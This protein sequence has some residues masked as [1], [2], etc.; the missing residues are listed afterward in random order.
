MYRIG[1]F[2][3]LTKTTIKTL[4][5][6]DEVGLVKPHRVDDENGYRYYTTAQLIQIHQIL[7]LRQAGLS[8]SEIQDIMSGNDR[9]EILR[10]K[11]AELEQELVQVQRRIARVNHILQHMKEDYFMEY[12]AIIK[13]LPACIV[14]SKRFILPNYDALFEIIPK[15]GEEVSQANPE[16]KCANPEYCF[17][18]DHD[19]EYKEKDINV[20][21]CE[22][23]TAYGNPVGDITFKEISAVDAVCVMHRGSY[24][25]LGKAYAFA[26]Q[27]IEENGYEIA[28]SPRESHIDGIWNKETEDEW[29]TEIQIPVK[30]EA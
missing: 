8:I 16:L 15:I 26:F 4:H 13:E 30:T 24:N 28:D 27:F 7:S 23:V 17:L 25:D 11:Q 29:L 3:K 5:Y 20:E 9:K 2:S 12:Q 10:G 18:V 6:Y 19:V 14:Y 22:A 21:F 1:E